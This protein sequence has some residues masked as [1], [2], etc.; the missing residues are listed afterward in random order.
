MLEK[1]ELQHCRNSSEKKSNIKILDAKSIPI[2]HKYKND[3]F[4]SL[5]QAP[6]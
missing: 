4:P 1:Q 2:K 3:H 5:A 6:Q